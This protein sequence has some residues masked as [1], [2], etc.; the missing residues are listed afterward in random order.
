MHNSALALP[1][2][3]IAL[4][5][6]WVYPLNPRRW[7]GGMAHHGGDVRG[8]Y[9]VGEDGISVLFLRTNPTGWEFFVPARTTLVV[10]FDS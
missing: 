7:K 1:L 2:V 5:L 6:E 8:L 10:M 9:F 4:A 3:Y